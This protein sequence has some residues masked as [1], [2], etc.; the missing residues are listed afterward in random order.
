MGATVMER[1]YQAMP[2]PKE[3]K[4]L[5]TKNC[6]AWPSDLDVHACCGDIPESFEHSVLPDQPPSASSVFLNLRRM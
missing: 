5:V 4:R 6:G 1:V 2:I 3:N